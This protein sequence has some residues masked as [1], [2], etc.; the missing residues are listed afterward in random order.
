VNPFAICM[1]LTWVAAD[2]AYLLV[3]IEIKK[4]EVVLDDG[5]KVRGG[6]VHTEKVS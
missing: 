1:L 3:L 5:A 4:T 2:V 6:M